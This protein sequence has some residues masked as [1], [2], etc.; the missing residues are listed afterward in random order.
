MLISLDKLMK[1]SENRYVFTKAGMEAVDKV[2]NMDD[3]PESDDTWKVVPN[4]LKLLLDE[5]LH[6]SYVP[7][8]QPENSADK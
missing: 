5:K 4:V 6:F 1:Y 7:E 3:Y 2:K 8:E